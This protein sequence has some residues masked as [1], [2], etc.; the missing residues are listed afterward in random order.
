MRVLVTG[1]W[2][3]ARERDDPSAPAALGAVAEGFA[4]VRPDW[5]V[6]TLPFGPGRAFAE[7]LTAI[8]GHR[9]APVLV[10]SWEAT[11]RRAGED[12]VE[13]LDAGL[14]P[15]VEG[16]HS[17]D[18]DAGL[19]FLSALAGWEVTRERVL[20]EG[21]LPSLGRA[22]ARLGGRDLVAATSTLR[23]LL[24]LA[25]T[26]A[27]GVDLGARPDQD[28]DLT[29]ALARSFVE[30]GVAHR[31]LPLADAHTTDASRLPGSG[32]AGGAAAMVAA[33]GGRIVASGTFLG[34]ALD[35]GARVGACDLLVVLE[36]HLDSP[37]LAEALL[38]TLTA[39]GASHALPVV[40]VGVDST[41]SSHEAAQWGLHGILTTG[42]DRGALLDV[43]RRVARTWAPR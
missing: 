7:A 40:A 31:G 14:V 18:V 9:W 33:L 15:V 19:G 41:L 17:I 25:S 8:P 12:V 13:A 22:G 21:L 30:V 16:G 35:L 36:P 4:A 29:G 43:G 5:E 20:T 38:D 39:A 10:E 3:G 37:L 34:E 28:R 1:H 32:A 27:I 6:Q 42:A 2:Q 11:T 24:G 26:M 23:P